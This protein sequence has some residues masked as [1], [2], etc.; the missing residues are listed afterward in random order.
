LRTNRLEDDLLEFMSPDT[1]GLTGIP[2]GGF[3]D[4]FEQLK[5]ASLFCLNTQPSISSRNEIEE[6]DW[7]SNSLSDVCTLLKSLINY[8]GPQ[9]KKLSVLEY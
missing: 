8:T 9:K 3:G 7:M 2:E 4:N 5:N 1:S 6:I